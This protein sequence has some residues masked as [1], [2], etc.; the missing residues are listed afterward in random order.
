MQY[1][2]WSF[3]Y[4]KIVEDF[5]YSIE[6]DKKAAKVLNELIIKP[7]LGA[8]EEKI[9][10][11]KILIFGA[12]PSLD[13]INKIPK[14]TII[15]ADGATT[16]LL[17]RGIVP[18]IVVTDLDGNIRDLLRASDK[19]SV[20]VLH[21]HGDNIN[22]IKSHAEDFKGAVGTTQSRPF[23]NLSNF[24]G[25]TDGDRAVFLAE[26]FGARE[27][28]LYGMDFNSGVGKYS[29]SKDTK[30]KRKKLKWGKRLI[31]HLMKRGNIRFE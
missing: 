2:E 29:F 12:G 31:G 9:K 19:G 7:D 27:V 25:F 23:G 26:H 1:S 16:F 4:K 28:L 18:D 5:G 21:A 17:E 3:F 8:L 15:A 14:G 10:D 22:K 24:G 20:I 30:I 13:E 6:E 11:K